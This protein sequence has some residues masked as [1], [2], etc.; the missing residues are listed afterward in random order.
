MR[1]DVLD[2][3]LTLVYVAARIGLEHGWTHIYSLSL[4]HDGFAHLRPGAAFTDG[5]RFISPPLLAWVLVPLTIIGAQAAVYVWLVVSMLA[6]AAAWWIAAPGRGPARTLWLLGAL[7]WYPLLYGV[8]L[9][10]PNLVVLAVVAAGWRLAERRPYFAGLV[11]GLS[12]FKPQLVLLLPLVLLAAGRWRIAASWAVTAGVLAVASVVI[13][14]AQGVSDYRSLLGEAQ[15]VVNNRYFTLAYVLGAGT[16]G[17]LA[18]AAV[19]ALAML[20]GYLNREAGLARL[21]ALGI[22]ATAFGAT[23][24]H[25][26]DFAM[27]VLAGWLFWRDGPPAWQRWWLLV[28]VVG[29]ELAWPLRPLPILVGVAVWFGVLVVPSRTADNLSAPAAA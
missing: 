29:G 17:Y 7:A 5:E 6:L 10:Q 3:D 1:V 19:G 2:N 22:V 14:G 13:I 21:F 4:Q 15:H 16:L 11:L 20:G 12:A 26:Q 9:A 8:G 24:W 23:Y 18:Q 28:V 25:L 27:L